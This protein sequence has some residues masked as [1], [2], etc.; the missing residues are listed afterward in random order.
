[1]PTVQRCFN[2]SAVVDK[3]APTPVWVIGRRIVLIG[4]FSGCAHARA[5]APADPLLPVPERIEAWRRAA[6]EPARTPPPSVAPGPRVVEDGAVRATFTLVR[7]EDAEWNRWS[8]G[9]R[10]FNDAAALLFQVRIEGP[11]PLA[12]A[13][14]GTTVELNDPSTRLPAAG[15]AEQLLGDL[16]VNAL[17]EERSG[18]GGD[19]VER[20]RGAG[21][22]RAAFLPPV[23]PG[24]VLEG[25]LAFPLRDG[26]RSLGDLHVVALRVV[27]A[28]DAADGRHELVSVLD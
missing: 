25:L 27:L 22:F 14:E 21:A 10:L 8:D 23:A 18:S 11:G 3:E 26:D 13:P 5:P 28:V 9:P 16:L 7:P 12:W 15:S 19:L 20:T 4:V 2:G 24:D 1:M 17:L 6:L